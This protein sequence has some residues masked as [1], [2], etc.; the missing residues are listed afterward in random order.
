MGIF[1]LA[2]TGYYAE[3]M[4]A[5]GNEHSVENFSALTIFV[6]ML[7]TGLLFKLSS[8]PGHF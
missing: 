8:F 4:L 2:G 3:V 5:L 1:M 7:I 6:A